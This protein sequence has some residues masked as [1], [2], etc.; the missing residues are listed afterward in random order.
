MHTRFQSYISLLGSGRIFHRI[1]FPSANEQRHCH[2][3]PIEKAET[4]SCTMMRA[5]SNVLF[6]A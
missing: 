3:D 5:Q 1:R 6:I 2:S 4:H